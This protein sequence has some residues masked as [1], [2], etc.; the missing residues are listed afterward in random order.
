VRDS[1]ILPIN[2]FCKIREQE[3]QRRRRKIENFNHHMTTRQVNQREEKTRAIS[4]QI[5]IRNQETSSL[6]WTVIMTD[7]CPASANRNWIPGYCMRKQCQ[8]NLSASLR[9]GLSFV[10]SSWRATTAGK[11][12]A[13]QHDTEYNTIPLTNFPYP[14]RLKQQRLVLAVVLRLYVTNRGSS[15][16][17]LRQPTV[18]TRMIGVPPISCCIT[19]SR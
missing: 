4:R 6:I 15:N 19:I 14:L 17:G 5:E 2:D 16:Y 11:Q 1:Q 13:N 3:S 8:Q 18:E 9:A 10:L 12:Y 7:R